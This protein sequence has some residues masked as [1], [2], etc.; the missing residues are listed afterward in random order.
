MRS[1]HG[2]RG[3]A[4]RDLAA[5]RR[6]LK[7]Q[8]PRATHIGGDRPRGLS[9][10]PIPRSQSP[11]TKFQ[12]GAKSGWRGT[13]NMPCIGVSATARSDA[14]RDRVQEISGAGRPDEPGAE[15][16]AHQPSPENGRPDGKS[17]NVKGFAQDLLKGSP[18]VP[19]MVVSLRGRAGLPDRETQEDLRRTLWK[20]GFNRGNFLAEVLTTRK[21]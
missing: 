10:S 12:A 2:R 7:P 4:G 1:P 8:S 14:A 20:I 3:K 6:L 5:S 17:P 15:G 21:R 11:G 13:P 19:Y 9:L 18:A 16:E